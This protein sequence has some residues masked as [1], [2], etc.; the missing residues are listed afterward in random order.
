MAG[1]ACYRPDGS[2]ARLAFHLREGA[3]DTDQLIP[4]V[5]RWGG[6]WAATRQ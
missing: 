4:I 6:Y 5:R 3:Y 1:V 2:D